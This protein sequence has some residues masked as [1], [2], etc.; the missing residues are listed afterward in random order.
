MADPARTLT[1]LLTREEAIAMLGVS[2]RT[3]ARRV[4]RELDRQ[5]SS[6]PGW[7]PRS[8]VA[9]PNTPV[10]WDPK[11][12]RPTSIRHCLSMD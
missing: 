1:R 10:F 9:R 11:I 8:H 2:K 7:L 5:L 4:E 12:D 6:D 3:F